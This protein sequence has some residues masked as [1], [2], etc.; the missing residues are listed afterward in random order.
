MVSIDSSSD[1]ASSTTSW[2]GCKERGKNAFINGDYILALESYTQA[3][4]H[5]P[6]PSTLD[7]Q[8][9]LS[10]IVACRLKIGDKSQAEAAVVAAKQCIS[11][12]DKWSKGHVRLASAYIMLTRTNEACNSLQTALKLDPGNKTARKMLMN[13]LRSRDNQDGAPDNRFNINDTRNQDDTQS[14]DGVENDIDIDFLTT[15][16]RIQFRIQKAYECY[17]SQSDEI[18]TFLQLILCFIVLYVAFGGRFGLGYLFNSDN[19]RSRGHTDNVYEE[20]YR[21][22]DRHNV[23]H[24][25][26]YQ[27]EDYSSNYQSQ[28]HNNHHRDSYR[29]RRSRSSSSWWDS[30][31]GYILLLGGV[32][33]AAR[34][35][36]ISPYQAMFVVNMMLGRQGRGRRGFLHGGR[37]MW[38]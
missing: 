7:R 12:N 1:D 21:D 18:K 38:R 9:L 26:Y 28:N 25:N 16:E 20:F 5:R 10:N 29:T 3:L 4:K 14:N 19:N 17:T 8:I 36:G 31:T 34:Y 2:L 11:L 15:G 6:G 37:G 33:F 32:T 22:R 30:G 35:F 24:R 13:E 23:Q 27:H